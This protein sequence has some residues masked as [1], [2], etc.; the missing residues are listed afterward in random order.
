[1]LVYDEREKKKQEYPEKNLSEQAENQQQTQ[2]TYCAGSGNRTRTTLVGGERSHHCAT[3][4][5]L[6][7]V[8]MLPLGFRLHA[9]L[10]HSLFFF[11]GRSDCMRK[12]SAMIT[13]TRAGQGS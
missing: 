6:F 13:M 2:P 8:R 11:M 7:S 5:P 10:V 1:M 3:P 9:G 12:Q 4:A